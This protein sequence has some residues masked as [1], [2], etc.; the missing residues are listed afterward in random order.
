MLFGRPPRVD[1]EEPAR[2]GDDPSGQGFL[3]EPGTG[4]PTIRETFD[5][6]PA[7]EAAGGHGVDLETQS[8]Q[9]SH[10]VL[11]LGGEARL[12]RARFVVGRRWVEQRED[13]LLQ[14][15]G[16]ATIE[17]RTSAD[18][19]LDHVLWTDRPGESIA[20]QSPVLGDAVNDDHWV[21]VNILHELGGRHG[22]TRPAEDVV[23]VELIEDQHAAE[24]TCRLH[25]A[26]QAV[27]GEELAR[28]VAGVA[29]EH[30]LQV[31][32]QHRLTE[33]M[34]VE[35]LSTVTAHHRDR[36][37]GGER[38]EQLFV[39]SVVRD[40]MSHVHPIE[41]R[42]DARE[43]CPSTGADGDVLPGVRLLPAAVAGVVKVRH[44]L[45]ESLGATDRP[46]LI[47]FIAVDEDLTD[48]GRGVRQGSRL[49]G[50]LAEVRPRRSTG[51]VAGG[52]GLSHDPDHTGGGDMT[53][54]SRFFAGHS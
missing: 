2:N 14:Q 46:V 37:E 36:H 1:E 24:L 43:S 4:V 19:A 21:V 11:A 7:V 25:P 33:P 30:R 29:E 16:G 23:G 52:R 41:R 35:P 50:A 17:V 9:L 38:A 32:V 44:R 28:R 40:D 42:C 51:L 54:G 10:E 53:E 12:D 45:A 13:R 15:V 18:Q 49:R 48:A 39:G 6:G 22:Q 34:R 27:S 47:V 3:E 26:S 20:R 31:E 5:L 8:P